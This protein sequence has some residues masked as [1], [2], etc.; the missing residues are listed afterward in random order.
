MTYGTIAPSAQAIIDHY[1]HLHI[2]SHTVQC[3][4]FNNRRSAMRGGLRVAI[5]KG[6]PKEIE[7]EAVVAALK[8]K[9]NLDS[10]TPEEAKKLL[11]EKKLGVDCSGFAYHLLDALVRAEKNKKLREVLI[12][13]K[14]KNPLRNLIKKIRTIENTSVK[15]LADEKN[16]KTISLSEVQPGDMITMIGT[17]Y[18]GIIDHILV[19][20]DIQ[21]DADQ[22]PILTYT[23]SLQWSSDGRFDHGVRTGTIKIINVQQPLIHQEW[24]EKGITN[25]EKNGTFRRAKDAKELTIKRLLALE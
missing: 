2:G 22:N 3:P 13:P 14:S 11:V 4:Y 23:H 12:L 25:T 15:V 7:E 1:T 18:T 21:K 6:T 9:I 20:T 10:L 5:G 16:S 24:T 17:G 19:I 8:S